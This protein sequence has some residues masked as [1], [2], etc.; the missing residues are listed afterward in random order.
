[1]SQQLVVSNIVSRWSQKHEQL[2]WYLMRQDAAFLICGSP[3]KGLQFTT[4]TVYQV[5][6]LLK[7]WFCFKQVAT[8][9]DAS[10]VTMAIFCQGIV[11]FPLSL[12]LRTYCG[13]CYFVFSSMHCTS[14]PTKGHVMNQSLDFGILWRKPNG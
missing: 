9:Q 12:W 13:I 14:K 11:F 3:C 4:N 1:M 2:F 5:C 7:S 8:L 10:L 6:L